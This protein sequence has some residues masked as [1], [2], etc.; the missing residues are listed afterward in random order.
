MVWSSSIS[1]VTVADDTT[2]RRPEK[3]PVH[4]RVEP[5]VLALV[6]ER[7]ADTRRTRSAM[8]ALMVAEA[9]ATVDDDSMSGKTR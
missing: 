2:P 7:A 4:F 8:L 5:D 9:V 1:V 6:D 3:V